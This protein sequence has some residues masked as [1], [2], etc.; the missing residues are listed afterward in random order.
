MD[1]TLIFSL[2]SQ[3]HWSNLLAVTSDACRHHSPHATTVLAKST[4]KSGREIYG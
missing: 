1:F 2:T 3:Q 4:F